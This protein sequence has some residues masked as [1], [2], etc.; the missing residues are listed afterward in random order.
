MLQFLVRHAEIKGLIVELCNKSINHRQADSHASTEITA[1]MN[2]WR[3]DLET[4]LD[5]SH[6]PKPIL[7]AFQGMTLSVLQHECTIILNRPLLAMGKDTPDYKSALQSCIGASRAIIG[8]LHKY[9]TQVIQG[10]NRSTATPLLWP[11]FTWASWQS[12]FIATYAAMEGEQPKQN[13]SRYVLSQL[14]IRNP[15]RTNNPRGSQTNPST[16]SNTSP[17]AAEYGPTPAPLPSAI[18]AGT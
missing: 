9:L 7:N 3:N 5:A 18:S 1:S 13:A 10:E 4:V 17:P 14:S 16:S 2:K 11:S 15:H 12:A 8:I 6:E